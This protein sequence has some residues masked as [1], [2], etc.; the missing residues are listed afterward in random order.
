MSQATTIDSQSNTVGLIQA[1]M[2]PLAPG[3]QMETMRPPSGELVEMSARR[4]L[5]LLLT[6][7]FQVQTSKKSRLPQVLL[8]TVAH[9]TVAPRVTRRLSRGPTMYSHQRH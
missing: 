9:Q 1:L 2:Y 5:M 6:T 3:C 4:N 7:Q 8:Q